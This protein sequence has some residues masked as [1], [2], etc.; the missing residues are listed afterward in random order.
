MSLQFDWVSPIGT[1]VNRTHNNKTIMI[2]DLLLNCKQNKQ[3]NNNTIIVGK[4]LSF[5]LSLKKK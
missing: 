5:P 2:L 4:F 3:V 1:K